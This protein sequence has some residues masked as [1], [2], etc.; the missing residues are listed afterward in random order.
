MTVL[1]DLKRMPREIWIQSL[2]ILINRAGTMVLP[3]LVIYLTKGLGFSARSAGFAITVYG[4][5]SVVASP[6]AGR[7]S[8][9][10][11]PMTVLITSLITSG[12]LL[13]IFPLLSQ[14]W[15]ILALTLTWAVAS[16]TFRPAS[17]AN[18][19]DLVGP[20]L[21]KPAVALIRLAVNLGM[22]IGPAVGG[23]LVLISFSSIFWIDGLTSILAGILLLIVWFK[24]RPLDH[25]SRHHITLASQYSLSP[26]ENGSILKDTRLVVFCIGAFLLGAVFFQHEAAMPLFLVRDLKLAEST[27]GFLFTVNTLIIVFVELPLN[28][29]M[30]N[31]SHRQSLVLGGV[32]CGLGFGSLAFVNGTLG[33]VATVV[34]WTFGEMILFPSM[35]AYVA[36]LAPA[37]RRGEYMGFYNLAFSL[38]FM[39]AP[40]AGTELL[41][42]AGATTLWG[43]CLVVGLLAAAIFSMAGS[44]EEVKER[45]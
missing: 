10:L 19:S 4:I 34:I 32:L 6:L 8:D 23:V 16:E 22:S 42:R 24:T 17:M 9:R 12:C 2:A 11:G 5:G 18:I 15:A 13:L 36:D 25:H 41:D 27:Y 44:T 3:F 21:R 35:V 37:H 31:W 7:L 30:A 45:I 28:S 26:A 20:D 14:Y 29:A 33:V 43:T 38:A 39:L 40:W 1:N